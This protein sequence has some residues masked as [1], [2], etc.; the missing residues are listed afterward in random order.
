MSLKAFETQRQIDEDG[1][2]FLRGYA[3]LMSAEVV[4]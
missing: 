4:V 2:N 1:E 3:L